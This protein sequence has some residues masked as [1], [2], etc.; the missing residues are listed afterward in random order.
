MFRRWYEFS[1]M[2]IEGGD[3]D[4]FLLAIYTYQF[5]LIYISLSAF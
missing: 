2:G 5:L 3:F 4:S 1:V